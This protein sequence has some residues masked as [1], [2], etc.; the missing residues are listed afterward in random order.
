D[1]NGKAQAAA[2]SLKLIRETWTEDRHGD[3]HQN[4]K[5]LGTRVLKTGPDGRLVTS[6][7][8]PSGGAYR[9]RAV[10]R[11][12]RGRAAAAETFAWVTAPG[13][14]I[15]WDYRDLSLS[16]D[17]ARYAPGDTAT[18]LIGSPRPGTPVLFTLEGEAVDRAVLLRG[19][20]SVLTYRFTVTEAMTR[21]VYASAAM[22]GG[23]AVYQQTQLLP[24]PADAQKLTVAV[25]G[26]AKPARPGE[27]ATF[28]VQVRGANGQPAPAQVG[29]GVVDEAVYL[30]RADET[31]SIFTAFHGPR[32]DGVGT[33]D[34][35]SYWFESLNAQAAPR[36]AM[37]R[38]VFADSKS[39]DKAASGAAPEAPR[40]DF[41]DTIAW[42]PRLVTG[43][44]GRAS[45][46]VKLPDNLTTYRA[47]ARALTLSGRAGEGRGSLLVTKDL[48]AR[49]PLPT[50]LV[51]GDTA[52]VPVTVQNTTARALTAS[53]TATASGLQAQGGTAATLNLAPGG[54]GAVPFTWTAGQAGD[55][56]LTA[57]AIS[58][59]LQDALKRPVKVLPRGYAAEAD[60]NLNLPA[61]Q[62]FTLPAD[63]APG[64]VTLNLELTPSLLAA[65]EPAI[66]YLAGYPYG[67]TEQTMSR[68]LPAILT[69]A[70]L[71]PDALPASLSAADL[72]AAATSG[73]ERLHAFQHE[74]GGWG[75]W[76]FDES[77][78]DMSAY[79]LDGLTRAKALGYAVPNAVL[80]QAVAF[81]ASRAARASERADDRSDAYRALATA[82]RLN[83]NAAR[84][85]SSRAGLSPYSLANLAA[86]FAQAGATGDAHAMLARLSDARREDRL[87]VHW[88]GSGDSLDYWSDNDI[89]VTARALEATL[90]VDPASRLVPG[91]QAWLLAARRGPRWVSTQDTAS[92]VEA[93]LQLPR[94]S[95]TAA[96]TASVRLNGQDAGSV[97][98]PPT[99]ASLRLPVTAQ[100]GT[101]VAVAVAAPKAPAGAIASLRLAYTRE[102]ASLGGDSSGDLSVTRTY[103]RLKP[104]WDEENA[105]Y[106][107][108]REPLISGGTLRPVAAGDIVLVTLRVQSKVRPVRYLAVSD[109]VPAG[110]TVV[111]ERA[112][113]IAG[114][115]DSSL[116]AWDYWY[117]GRD[118][119]ETSLDFYAD[120]LDGTRVLQYALRATT[121]GAY[122]ALPTTA[123]AMYDPSRSA[124]GAAATLRVQPQAR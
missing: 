14:T 120:W 48:I 25:T 73:I 40:Q 31:P 63:A 42:V 98:V 49:L 36:P 54:R 5:E 50:Y 10:A 105:R 32:Q 65:V 13:E 60:A 17:R 44:D 86:A 47:T 85:F 64:S 22:I 118:Q 79:V 81:V 92:V 90:R 21:G 59:D 75:F 96:F 16:F 11:D 99:G 124:R 35:L 74:D 9:I 34:G 97:S 119:R 43:P 57:S 82:G 88:A 113:A 72:K 114:L 93:A 115:P 37:S 76:T 78:L 24:V 12:S 20:G 71:G 106:T 103:E 15:Y 6:V 67:C 107:M 109:P 104:A 89:Q 7:A 101:P 91:I 52:S 77:T 95:S 66:E 116:D 38:A 62:T 23:N 33:A 29:L 55:G 84:A 2:V 51:R 122:T 3:W 94:P 70:A 68:F 87:G 102:P 46:T 18:V 83:L 58:G 100:P 61:A 112:F 121:A 110:F 111:D 4:L 39:G 123:F 53:V 19:S 8:L 27:D 69:R 1:L 45:V 117:A 26:P 41:R 30:V 56:T 108:T 80:D 28:A